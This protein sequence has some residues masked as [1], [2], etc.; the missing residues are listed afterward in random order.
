MEVNRDNFFWMLPRMLRAAETAQFVAIDLEMSGIAFGYGHLSSI[1]DA[2]TKIKE[3]AEA[4]QVLQIGFTFIFNDEKTSEYATRSFNCYVS[5]LFP[6]GHFTGALTRHLDRAFTISARSYS[7]LQ[8]HGFD[9]NQAFDNGVHYLSRKEQRLAEEFCSFKDPEDGRIDPST[10]DKESQHFYSE[11]KRQIGVYANKKPQNWERREFILQNPYGR[12]L[13]GLQIRMIHQIIREE[14]PTCTAKRIPTG[15]MTGN[16]SITSVTTA[17]QVE[18]ESRRQLNVDETKRLSGLQILLEAL[19][20]GSFADRIDQEWV[21]HSNAVPTDADSWNEFNQ[22]F[23]FHQCEA[24]LKKNQPILIGHNIFQDLAYIHQTFFEPLP[25]KVD[26]FL[27]TIHQLFPRIVDTKYMHT[28]GRNMMEPDKPLKEL[29]DFFA[30]KKLPAIHYAPDPDDGAAGP[31]NAA[32]DSTMTATLFLKQTHS[33]FNMKK[34][35]HEVKEAYYAPGRQAGSLL[36]EEEPDVMGALRKWDVLSPDNTFSREATPMSPPIT[37]SPAM[38]SPATP[39]LIPLSPKMGEQTEKTSTSTNTTH[40]IPPWSD[41][42]WRTY[43]NKTLIP[44]A[45]FVSFV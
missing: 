11:A 3:A 43:G 18:A 27:T 4:Y 2:Y 26:G 38:P 19:S 28:R 14:Y 15:K 34:H 9:F 17:T 40:L 29:R 20:G 5:P 42:F 30:K 23:N 12:R 33:M 6:K 25:P 16:M 22:N 41:A 21:Y 44:G 36:D 8:S 32:Y 7:F 31:H 39:P 1:S 45:G 24:N 37:P 35:L 13:N 10:L